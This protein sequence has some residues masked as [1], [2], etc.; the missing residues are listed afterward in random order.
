MNFHNTLQAG[1]STPLKIG[2]QLRM[3]RNSMRGAEEVIHAEMHGERHARL[4]STAQKERVSSH[5]ACGSEMS[6]DAPSMVTAG[7]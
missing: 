7:S 4:G 3:S 6:A 2:P 5:P 1:C